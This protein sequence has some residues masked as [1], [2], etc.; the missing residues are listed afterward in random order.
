MANQPDIH[1]PAVATSDKNADNLAGQSKRETES[2]AASGFFNEYFTGNQA[3]ALAGSAVAAAIAIKLGPRAIAPMFRAAEGVIARDSA[4]VDEQ[5]L[6]STAAMAKSR[7]N[8]PSFASFKPISQAES[9][10]EETT[11]QALSNPAN[12]PGALNVSADGW[13]ARTYESVGKSVVRMQRENGKP[14]GSGFVVDA[15]RNLI[16][17]SHHLIDG[18][19]HQP[20][21]V[22]LPSGQ[23]LSAKVIGFDAEA[24]V[25]V[26]KLTGKPNQPLNALDLGTPLELRTK[27]A[28][29]IGF[30]QTS[31][32]VPVISPGRFTHAAYT[33]ESRLYFDM[34]TYFGNSGG[35]IVNREGQVLGLVKTG[36][37]AD[38]YSNAGTIGANVEHLRALLG[39]VKDRE[40]AQ[41]P[42]SLQ[43]IILE[44]GRA[45]VSAS[46]IF[47]L[48]ST[49]EVAADLARQLS[50]KVLK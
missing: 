47:A 17:T 30:P 33:G 31:P 48:K 16:A 14:L 20:Q 50:V 29:A 37:P 46:D 19:E 42:L 5:A 35:P 9:L 12:K 24:D 26:L 32:E 25:A 7:V 1:I 44:R 28:A 2:A 40:I 39:L 8:V 27:R 36:T 38:Q 3:L 22:K 21:F 10:A 34:K 41:G 49:P 4:A 45:M 6:S 43:S 15:D 18:I 13:L 23:T 11:E